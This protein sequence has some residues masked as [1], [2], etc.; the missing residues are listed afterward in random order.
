MIDRFV[1]RAFKLRDGANLAHWAAKGT[2]SYARHIAL[3]ELYSAIIEALDEIV[4]TYQGMHGLISVNYESAKIEP[5]KILDAIL[6]E[7]EWVAA[8]KTA[9]ANG[10]PSVAN[11]LDEYHG[12][13]ART[14]YKL[15]NLQ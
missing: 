11:L 14:A 12:T 4:E 8:N 1:A 6:G 5:D 13:L 15:K 3:G 9:I 10:S 2:G 7:A